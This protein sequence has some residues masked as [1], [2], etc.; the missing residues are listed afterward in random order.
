[1]EAIKNF[2]EEKALNV[3]SNNTF[4]NCNQPASF[5]YNSAIDHVDK[6]MEVIEEN[7]KLHEE[8]KNLYERL[9]QAEKNAKLI[10]SINKANHKTCLCFL[11]RVCY[12]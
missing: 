6:W 12:H 8:N 1:V 7:K 11:L 3:I 2:S 9:L 10:N 4:E 5:F